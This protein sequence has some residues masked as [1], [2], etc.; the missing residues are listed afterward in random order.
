MSAKQIG[1]IGNTYGNLSVK[2]EQ[3]S[4]GKPLYYWSIEDWSGDDWYRIDKT[5][6]TALLAHQELLDLEQNS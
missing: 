4:N 2:V 6:F 1:L 5:L 3:D